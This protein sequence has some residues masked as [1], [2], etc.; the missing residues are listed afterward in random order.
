MEYDISKVAV[1][2][3]EFINAYMVGTKIKLVIAIP[4]RAYKNAKN[5]LLIFFVYF[6]LYFFRKSNIP[7]IAITMAFMYPK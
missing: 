1:L 5:N 4:I 6:P 2:R 3:H 7:Y